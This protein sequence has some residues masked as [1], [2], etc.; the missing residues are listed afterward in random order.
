MYISSSFVDIWIL[1]EPDRNT[2][3][4]YLM[5]GRDNI[6]N[7]MNAAILNNDL[8]ALMFLSKYIKDDPQWTYPNRTYK[9]AAHTHIYINMYYVPIYRNTCIP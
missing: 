9:F 6:G 1:G 2:G 3:R 5:K 7:A 4:A 8:P